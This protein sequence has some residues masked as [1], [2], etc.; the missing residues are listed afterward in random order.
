MEEEI[1]LSPVKLLVVDENKIREE[2]AMAKWRV[3]EMRPEQRLPC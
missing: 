1:E 3:R 2:Q